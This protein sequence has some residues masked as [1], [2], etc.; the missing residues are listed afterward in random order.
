MR[1]S[2]DLHSPA[3][4]GDPDRTSKTTPADGGTNPAESGAPL[5]PLLWKEGM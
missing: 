2:Q 5:S 1:A 3:K 4:Y